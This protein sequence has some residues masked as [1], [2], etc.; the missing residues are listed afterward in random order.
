MPEPSTDRARPGV[1][2]K[3][4][5]WYAEEINDC[6]INDLNELIKYYGLKQYKIY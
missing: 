1:E 3:I 2:G 6:R 4:L 5:P